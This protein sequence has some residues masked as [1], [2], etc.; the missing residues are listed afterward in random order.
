MQEGGD[1]GGALRNIYPLLNIS[2]W[3]IVLNDKTD[4]ILMSGN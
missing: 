1:G 2:P 3:R 4:H